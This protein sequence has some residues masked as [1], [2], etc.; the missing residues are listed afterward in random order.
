MNDIQVPSVDLDACM[1]CILKPR[2]PFSRL[3]IYTYRAVKKDTGWFP[4]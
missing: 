3:G 2:V 1:Q 4:H